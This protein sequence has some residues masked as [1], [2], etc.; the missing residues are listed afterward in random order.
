VLFAIANGILALVSL[1]SIDELYLTDS[2][3]LYIVL[4][5]T[6]IAS[7]GVVEAVRIVLDK[8]V[9]KAVLICFAFSTIVQTL[10][11]SVET[12]LGLTSFFRPNMEGTQVEWFFNNR[13]G[14]DRARY[15]FSSPMTA[16]S[17]AWFCGVI[18]LVL[19][20][21]AKFGRATRYFFIA[22][23]L[24]AWVGMAFCISR[25]PLLVACISVLPLIVQLMRGKHFI[26]TTAW[27]IP[28]LFVAISGG[29]QIIS[30]DLKYSFGRIIS[31]AFSFDEDG[32]AGRATVWSEGLNLISTVPAGGYGMHTISF[33]S[34]DYEVNF[35][36][37]F[38]NLIYG[39]GYPGIV[40]S[41]L[42]I[43]YWV[44]KTIEM[45]KLLLSGKRFDQM[46]LMTLM[47][48]TG[49]FP[50]MFVYPCLREFELALITF[51]ILAL[52][53]IVIPT[54]T[55]ISSPIQLLILIKFKF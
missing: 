2:A 15:S 18:L 43:G 41:C 21:S 47:L 14:V 54:A 36:N 7:L 42:L 50:Y 22:T 23:G 6:P 46:E 27:A 25:G 39:L 45:W 38:L 35:E 49:W 30:D 4:F 44:A 51:S 19:G 5:A 29:L 52:L 55:R 37:T 20:G 3:P 34:G 1:T 11:L 26:S 16:G 31:E 48:S 24:F 53:F 32:N 28:L 13:Y 17:W 12:R 9:G 40:Y 8:K 10:W 33:L